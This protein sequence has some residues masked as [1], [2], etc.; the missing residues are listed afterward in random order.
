LKI[1][2][3]LKDISDKLW[4]LLAPYEKK[5]D[6]ERATDTVRAILLCSV[7]LNEIAEAENQNDYLNYF[8][9][10]KSKE[11]FANV[12]ETLNIWDYKLNLK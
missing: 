5:N 2:P 11:R 9:K 10:V 12:I 6:G 3:Y 1:I 4:T 8:A 7:N